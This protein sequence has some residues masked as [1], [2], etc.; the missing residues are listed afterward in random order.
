MARE[1]PT[2]GQDYYNNRNGY[3]TE[4]EMMDIVEN[5]KVDEFIKKHNLK[6]DKCPCELF[7][8]RD[9]YKHCFCCVLCMKAAFSYFG[10]E[11]EE[12]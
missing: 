2:R 1:E 7:I 12:N 10:Y 4:K 5:N 11:S 6:T 8:H 3:L 9:E